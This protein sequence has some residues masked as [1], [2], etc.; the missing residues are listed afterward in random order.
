[1]ALPCLLVKF[2]PSTDMPQHLSQ[3]RLLLEALRTPD[4]PYLIQPLTPYW[5]ANALLVPLWLALPTRWLASAAVL[6]L[7]LVWMGA[8]HQVAG[9]RGRAPE[10]AVLASLFFFSQSLYWGFLPFLAGWPAYLAW[11]LLLERDDGPDW[12][13]GALLLAGAALLYWLHALWFAMALLTLVTRWA[14]RRPGWRTVLVQ[15]AAVTP[16]GLLAL[17]WF[18]QL[19]Q[20][21]FKSPA[22][23]FRDAL[24]RLSPE[25]LTLAAF[26]GLRE[27]VEQPLLL[28]VFV[29][30]GLGLWQHRGELRQHVDGALLRPG[31]LLLACALVLP[32]KY[33]NT[34]Y[35]AERWMPGALALLLLALPPPRLRER[36]LRTWAVASVALLSGFTAMTWRTFERVELSGL[37]SSLEAIPE[38]SRVL[39]LDF[40]KDS[41]LVLGRPFLQTFAY[42]QVLRGSQLNFSFAWHAPSPV[43][44]RHLRAPPWRQGLE[45]YPERASPRDLSFFDYVLVVLPPE[46]HPKFQA[47]LG[48]LEPITQ[49]GPWRLYRVLPP[50]AEAPPAG[51]GGAPRP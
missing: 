12:R 45:W 18:P 3:V 31:L 48:G 43:I 44:L 27:S 15:G 9:R 28:L 40:V 13:R 36:V 33:S 24:E 29:W 51:G 35:L 19:S 39:G 2:P 4:G 50:P 1:V 38:G 34:I 26:G 46:E 22:Y 32:D 47:A 23:W 21:G 49:D 17:W 5:G 41:S 11:V 16:V 6:A 30:L 7:G 37:E 25:G 10:A 14:V 20:R 42:A 8:V